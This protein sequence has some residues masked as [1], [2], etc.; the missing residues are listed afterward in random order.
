MEVGNIVRVKNTDSRGIIRA[1]EGVPPRKAYVDLEPG[2]ESGYI[3]LRIFVN[4]EDR[5]IPGGPAGPETIPLNIYSV[6]DLEI[7]KAR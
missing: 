1:L 2:A 4:A 3:Y 5:Y 6:D 7:V